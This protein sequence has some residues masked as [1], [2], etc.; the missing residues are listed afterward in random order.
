MAP[1]ASPTIGAT[2]LTTAAEPGREGRS[3]SAMAAESVESSR[4]LATP[5]R[6]RASKRTAAVSAPWKSAKLAASRRNPMVT[7]GRR[8]TWSETEPKTSRVPSRAT[9]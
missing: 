7:T 2:A 9:A 8:P 3:K 1:I 5:C 6:I 4:P